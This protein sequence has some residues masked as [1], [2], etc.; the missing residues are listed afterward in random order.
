MT[1]FSST[2]WTLCAVKRTQECDKSHVDLT[3]CCG[4]SSNTTSAVLRRVYLTWKH[5]TPLGRGKIS[6][7]LTDFPSTNWT[8]CA[9]KIT[10]ECDESPFNITRYCSTSL[11]TT[12]AVL[13]RID[14]T[15]NHPKRL[16]RGG[17]FGDLSDFSSTNWT[18]CAVKRNEECD[19][20]GV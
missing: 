9:I 6:G 1:D 13:R 12:S 14:L 3:W 20:S 19:D 18:L 2:N 16:D 8:L 11:V 17:F 5:P 4:K 15:W 10:E 7:D